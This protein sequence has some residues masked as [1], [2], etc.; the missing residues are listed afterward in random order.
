M[1]QHQGAGVAA[2][3]AAVSVATSATLI[4]PKDSARRSVVIYNNGS[5]DVFLGGSGVTTAT[6]LVLDPGGSFT[7]DVSI[8]AW[9]GIVASGTVEVRVA[10]VTDEVAD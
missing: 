1:D 3:P 8:S 10:V 9:Y 7:D 4:T 2:A 6:G 5:A